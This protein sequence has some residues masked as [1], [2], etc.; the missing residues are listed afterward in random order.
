MLRVM[1]RKRRAL[2]Q[3]YAAQ[4]R[5]SYRLAMVVGLLGYAAVC[6]SIHRSNLA[7]SRSA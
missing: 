6:A 4:N 5:D 2:G 3:V 1:N 7:W